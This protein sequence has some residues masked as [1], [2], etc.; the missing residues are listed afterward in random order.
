MKRVKIEGWDIGLYEISP[1]D[2]EEAMV[3]MTEDQRTSSEASIRNLVAEIEGGKFGV[4]N[5][6]M[7]KT[8]SGVF[9]NGKHRAQAIIRTGKTVVV[10]VMT[11]PDEC[12]TTILRI[13]DCGVTRTIAHLAQMVIGVRNSLVVAAVAKLAISMERGLLTCLGCYGST[14]RTT[15]EKYVSRD[16]LLDYM[17]A[18][19]AQLEASAAVAKSLNAEYGLLGTHGPAF[20]HYIVSKKYSAKT[21]D[22]FLAVLFSGKG[23]KSDS[24]E[25]IRKALIKDMRS[26][27]KIP[28]AVKIASI[29]KTFAAWNNGTIPTRGFVGVDDKLPT[30]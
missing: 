20:V 24:V 18:H 10:A 2:A 28:S 16:D 8:V 13:M 5:D 17:K 23:E 29:M 19:A 21:A 22:A 11:V 9:L 30:M 1:K 14:N 6:A 25:P 26:V 15:Q 4:S 7:V 27:R 12:A 3:A